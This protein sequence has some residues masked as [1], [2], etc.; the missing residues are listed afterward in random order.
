MNGVDWINKN[1]EVS[2]DTAGSLMFDSVDGNSKTVINDDWGQYWS[3]TSVELALFWDDDGQPY[4]TNAIGGISHRGIVNDSG[5]VNW[6][7]QSGSGDPA[8]FD[9]FNG[10]HSTHAG[11]KL[12]VDYTILDMT[13]LTAYAESNFPYDEARGTVNAKLILDISGAIIFHE[14]TATFAMDVFQFYTT[15]CRMPNDVNKVF[16]S[17]DSEVKDIGV[18]T[19]RS[20]VKSTSTKVWGGASETVYDVINN[21]ID[22]NDYFKH[23]FGTTAMPRVF[24]SEGEDPKIYMNQYLD[25]TTP[26]DMPID[27]VLTTRFR[28]KLT[29]ES[30][31]AV[32][33]GPTTTEISIMGPTV[34]N[35]LGPN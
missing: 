12:L 9:L 28:I 4:S 13:G 19:L 14:I 1:S 5:T 29:D 35:I 2:P 23:V 30:L 16:F 11:L 10:L 21:N 33:S 34:I 3:A 8:D 22:D 17:G 25:E 20:P 32:G 6:Q 31:G 26:L 27:D 15:Q 24:A 7:S 18:A